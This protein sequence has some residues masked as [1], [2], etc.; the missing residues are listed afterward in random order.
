MDRLCDVKLVLDSL[1]YSIKRECAK[2]VEDRID[3]EDIISI[4]D[5]GY[6][7]VFNESFTKILIN[8]KHYVI[9]QPCVEKYKRLYQDKLTSLLV[10]MVE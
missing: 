7:T 9:K 10:K 2:Y 3:K 1:A 8:Q 6:G 5:V 4:D